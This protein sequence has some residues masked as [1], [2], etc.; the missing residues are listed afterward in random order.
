MTQTA[1]VSVLTQY[2]Q[3]MIVADPSLGGT[4]EAFQ[5]VFY[6]DQDLVPRYPAIAVESAH[7]ESQLDGANY[8]T[9]NT[10]RVVII[11]YASKVQ[12]V[13]ATRLQ[14]DQIAVAVRTKLHT[15][16]TMGGNVIHGFVTSIEYGYAVRKASGSTSVMIRAARLTWEGITKVAL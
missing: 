10:M 14:A 7:I 6:G 12:D 16:R 9:R 13:Q 3:A 1:D 8:V 15:D 11:V 2:I 5:D 4:I